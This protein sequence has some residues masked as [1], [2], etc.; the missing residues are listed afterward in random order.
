MAGRELRAFIN[1]RL[2]GTLRE[3]NDIWAFDYDAAWRTAPDAYDL[4]PH[5]PRTQGSHLDGASSRPVQWYFDNLLPEEALR[6]VLAREAQL[7]E[8]DAFSLLAWF[9]AESAGSLVLRPPE[10]DMPARAGLRPLSDAD[11]ARRIRNL[12]QLSLAHDAP[13]HMSLAG[14][15]HKL[16]VVLQDGELYEPYPG[17]V[18]THILK[19]NSQ[20]ALYPA[21]ASNEYFVMRLAQTLGLDTPAVARRYVPEAVYLIERFDR[22]RTGAG[23]QRLHVIDACQL[24]NKPRGFKYRAAT[25]ETL[26][27][28]V[29]RCRTRAQARL[30]LFQWLV[31]NVLV[32][33]GDNH[34]KNISFMVSASGID[35]AP[36]YDLLSTAA[37]ATPALATERA[38]WPHVELALAL[39]GAS[40]FDAVSAQVLRDA[41]KALGLAPDTATREM[42]RM[43]TRI[44]PA[45]D[46]VYAQIAQE[47]EALSEAAKPALAGELHVL[48]TIRH[49]VIADMVRR[50]A[51]GR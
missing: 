26:L 1:D 7:D 3:D 8:D 29:R 9:G 41:G 23:V 15:Q 11:L 43:L 19:P 31:F 27:D 2:V 24:L 16:P 10:D 37:Y 33:N 38:T 51:A 28:V 6:T 25:V 20:S 22:R 34:L 36:A 46:A 5:L 39:P 44:E 35:I 49:V 13:K 32:G 30:R 21:S 12:P 42:T 40:H 17:E 45:A 47:N 4:S 48:R 50:L 18:S 14:A